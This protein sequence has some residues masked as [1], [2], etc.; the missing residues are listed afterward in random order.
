MELPSSPHTKTWKSP[1]LLRF[2]KTEFRHRKGRLPLPQIDGILSRL[3]K[4]NFISSLDLKD[5]FWQI[6]LEKSSR[7]KTAFT[8]PG[9][10]L[11]HFTSM[12]FGLCN[13]PQTLTR[14]MDKV[15]P[16]TLRDRVF[17]YLDDLL[18]ISEDCDSHLQILQQVAAHFRKASLTI[19]VEKSHFLLKEVHYL[20]YIV[21]N[22]VLKINPDKVVAIREYP[23]PTSV[24]QVRRF[25]GMAGYY[26]RFI[27]NFANHAAPIS[28]LL[29]NPKSKFH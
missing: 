10:P 8:V 28:N 25:L 19:N 22:G 6:P 16:H 15:I 21:G 3:P 5:A 26:R 23:K 13:A 9:R 7:L 29:K 4:A 1:T 27:N 17:V 11:Y 12:P 20:G 18:V 24:R 2:S 14:L